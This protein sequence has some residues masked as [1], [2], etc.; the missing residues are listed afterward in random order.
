[1]VLKTN[2]DLLVFDI[3][4]QKQKVNSSV[5]ALVRDHFKIPNYLVTSLKFTSS[6]ENLCIYKNYE[7]FSLFLSKNSVPVIQLDL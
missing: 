6:E 4:N 3:A 2:G 7:T 1:M 5:L